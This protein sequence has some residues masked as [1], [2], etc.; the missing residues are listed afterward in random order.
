MGTSQSSSGPG[1]SSPLVPPWA[2]DEPQKPLPI[3]PRARFKPFR[4]SLGR[5]LKT[6]NQSDL[7]SALYNYAQKG[8]GGGGIASRRL[9]SATNAGARLYRLLSSL[10][11]SKVPPDVLIDLDNL[12]GQ[13]CDIA[14]D[15]ITR[16]L[17]TNDGDTEKIRVAMNHAL[18]EA[19]DGIAVFDPTNITDDIIITIMINYLSEVVFLQIVMDA[20]KAWTNAETATQA[21][22][23]ENTLR[24]L[25]KVIV[26]KNMAPRL[27][28]NTR[29]FTK[30]EMKTLQREVIKIVW[31]EWEGYQ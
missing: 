6:N 24:E 11:E 22:T 30:Q 14:I 7:K 16:S 28:K 3:P 17:A 31:R 20:G 21:V 25:I 5:F 19:L 12:K 1:G 10:A 2:D 26:D 23:V 29:T 4:Q 13:P 18:V 27:K 8:T 9:G 15:I